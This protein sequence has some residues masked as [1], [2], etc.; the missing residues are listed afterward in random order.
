L[1]IREHLRGGRLFLISLLVC[2]SLTACREE[3]A[4]GLPQ[5]VKN[6]RVF[7]FSDK[8]LFKAMM[9]ILKERGFEDP[10][11]D[12]DQGKVETE[13]L[14]Q[15]NF[16][17]KVEARVKK[18]GRRENEVTLSVAT[19]QNTPSGWKPKN[20]MEKAQYDKFFDEIEIQAY[21]ELAKA[22]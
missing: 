2:L 7:E 9:N 1:S 17:T 12:M 8:I 16:R 22:E 10:K 3:S 20:I 13:Y 18:V 19:E 14:V 4:E 6:T 21:R 11:V 5:P 15:E